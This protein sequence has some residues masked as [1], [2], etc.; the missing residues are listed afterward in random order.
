[1]KKNKETEI[2]KYLEKRFKKTNKREREF[3]QP[4]VRNL[5]AK[6]KSGLQIPT[7]FLLSF[8]VKITHGN[9]KPSRCQPCSV[10]LSLADCRSLGELLNAR[11]YFSSQD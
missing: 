11:A 4:N 8:E 9:T 10:E 2:V 6:L 1:M 7:A 3:T 5:T